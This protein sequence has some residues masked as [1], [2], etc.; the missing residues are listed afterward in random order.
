[1]GRSI[2]LV[3]YRLCEAFVSLLILIFISFGLLRFFPGSPLNQI[4]TLDP[5]VAEQL[6]QSYHLQDSF[7]SQFTQ[8][9]HQI[10]SGDL[11]SSM[12]FIGRTVQSLIWEFGQTSLSLGLAAFV[13]AMGFALAYTFFTRYKKCEKKSDTILLWFLSVPSIAL[14]PFLI[15]FFGFYLNWL[16]VALLEKSASYI[17][18]IAL[19]AFK[20]SL[21]LARVLSSSMDA[22]L[23]ENYIQ[24]ARALG[25]SEAQVIG[26]WALR[27]SWIPLLAQVGPLFASLISGSFLVEVLFSIPGLGSHFVDSVLNRDWPLILGLSIF[28]GSL[29]IFSQLLTDLLSR[30][31]DPRMKAL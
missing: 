27:N 17:L 10:L 1:M 12:H 24:T 7:W 31:V 11:G 18:P 25:F 23:K 28:Y 20:P 22:T 9:L 19:L 8:Y 15:W 4:E 3:F 6:K 16:P 21:T 29:L 30:K 26:K 14:G 13:I 5:M 2:G